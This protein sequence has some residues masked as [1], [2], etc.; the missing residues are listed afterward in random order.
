MSALAAFTT[1]ELAREVLRRR[2]IEDAP[3]EELL[4]VLTRRVERG[5][6]PYTRK[7]I[8]E[9]AS[10][11]LFPIGPNRTATLTIFDDDYDALVGA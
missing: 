2:I 11:W 1:E 3:V 6:A 5:P 9:P 7:L 8:G 4:R 10:E